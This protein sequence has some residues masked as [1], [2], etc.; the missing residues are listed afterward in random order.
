MI[1]ALFSDLQY[2]TSKCSKLACKVSQHFLAWCGESLAG[3]GGL[4]EATIC[5]QSPGKIHHISSFPKV[6]HLAPCGNIWLMFSDL[7]SYLI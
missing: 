2:S 4:T 5:S 1:L 6:R 3:G 7:S